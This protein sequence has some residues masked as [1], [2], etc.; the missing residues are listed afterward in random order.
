MP[1][2]DDKLD[3][4][5]VLAL[6]ALLHER[7]V[8]RAAARVGLGQPA[9]SHALKRLRERFDDPLLVRGDGR[10]MQLTP[11]AVE[12]ADLAQQGAEAIE[13]VFAAPA[14]FDPATCT[15]RFRVATSDATNV[16]LLPQLLARLAQQAP[17]VDLEL[18]VSGPGVAAALEEGRLDLGV[19]RWDLAPLGLR[20]RTLHHDR[21]V[22]VA[23]AD[24]P[25]VGRSLDLATYVA[26]PHILVAPRGSP[27][28]VVD[29]ALTRLGHQRRIAVV[30]QSFVAAMF[31]ASKTDLLVTLPRRVVLELERP[32]AVRVLEPPLPLPPL[33]LHLVW[34]ERDHYDPAHRW[35]RGLVA[36]VMQGDDEPVRA[37]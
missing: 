31:V 6:H 12:L 7:S 36:S 19:G 3:A 32:L 4:N 35:L 5:L 37:P 18:P 17:L 8:S 22:T 16:N 25:R 21:L 11:R 14:P 15:R 23:R 28:G 30:M 9:M 29:E 10:L 20:R 13:R 27:R 24:H 26:L 34:H 33:E 2:L 1:D